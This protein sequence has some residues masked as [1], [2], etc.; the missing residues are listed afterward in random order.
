MTLPGDLANDGI[1]PTPTPQEFGNRVSEL[2]LGAQTALSCLGLIPLDADATATSAAFVRLYDALNDTDSA[3]SGIS[4]ALRLVRLSFSCL[5][6]KR[7]DDLFLQELLSL[8][9][10]LSSPILLENC[11]C[12]AVRGTWGGYASGEWLMDK[13]A[14]EGANIGLFQVG[15]TGYDFLRT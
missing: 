9:I 1:I 4:P 7:A 13:L 2:K 5:R 8:G 14:M 12:K 6:S 15:A 11:L 10:D 3:V